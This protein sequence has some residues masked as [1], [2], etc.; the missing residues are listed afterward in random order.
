MTTTFP[1][2]EV[3]TFPG[4]GRLTVADALEHH[5]FQIT[6]DRTVGHAN[7][8][9]RSAHVPYLLVRDHDGRCEGLVTRVAMSPFLSRSRYSERT[10]VGT[11]AHQ[12]GPFAWPT[13]GLASAALAMRTMR[14]TVWPVVDDDGYL[15]GVITSDRVGDLLALA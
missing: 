7:E 11:T 5:D 12:R 6:D 8:I 10:L 15:L 9:F 14:L 4:A 3:T 13:M 1:T 2:T